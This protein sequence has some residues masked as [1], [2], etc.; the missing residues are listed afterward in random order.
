MEIRRVARIWKRGGL[1]WKSEKCA[2]DV[3]SNFHW[4]WISFRG[5]VRNLR[6]NVSERSE[7]QRF[8]SPKIRWSPKKKKKSLRQNSEWFFGRNP[9][10]KRFF[11]PKLGDLQKKKRSSP[12][13]RAI[14]LPISQVQTFEGGLFSYGGGYFPFFT[15]NRPQ[16]HKKHAFLHTSQANGGG[17]SPPAP[18]LATL[19]VEIAWKI[20]VKT[21]FFLEST[22]ACVL[23]SWPWPRAFLSLASRV[24]VLGKAVLGLGLGFFLGPW[25]WPRI[26]FVSLALASSLVSSTPPLHFSRSISPTQFC[27]LRIR[28]RKTI[29]YRINRY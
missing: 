13:F 28:L 14:F 20:F 11:R 17:S 23:G 2:N 15:E 6:Q 21:F 8:F 16:K 22:C 3:D 26:F 12:K 10:F 5:F 25:P 24:S 1:F 9:K 18:P 29:E 7:I 27:I 4:P 19:L